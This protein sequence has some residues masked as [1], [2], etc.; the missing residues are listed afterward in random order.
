MPLNEKSFLNLL[1]NFECFENKPH[2]AVGVS[3]GPDSMALVYLLNKWIKSKKGKLIALIFDH[4]IRSNSKEESLMVKYMLT[5]IN[6]NSVIIKPNKNKLIR[7]NMANARENRFTGMINFCKKKYI[8][9]LFLGHH[10]DDNLETYLI[11]KINGSNLEGL[12]A[13]NT[14]TNFNN[15]QIIRPFIKI[16]KSTILDFNK[17]HNVNFINDPSNKNIN[18]TRVKVR[19]FFQ[20]KKIKREV[21]NDFLKIKKEIPSYKKMIWEIFIGCLIDVSTHKVKI[22]FNK[23]IKLDELIIEKLI[24]SLLKFLIKNKNNIKSSKIMIF[25]DNLKQPSFKTFNLNSV[26]IQKKSDFLI[27]SQK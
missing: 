24:L 2:I 11:R 7:Q 6:I 22:N 20:D 3:G 27:F 1:K 21:K 26:N 15:I 19:N 25:I 10:Y 9:H 13:I 14:I 16:S 23:L 4:E 18:Y 5:E 8:P 12:A 17:K